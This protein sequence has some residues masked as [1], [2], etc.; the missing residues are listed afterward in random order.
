[1]L[2]HIAAR[3]NTAHITYAL[4]ASSLLYFKGLVK[5][6]HDFDFEVTLADALRARDI[7]RGMGTLRPSVRGDYKI[8]YSFEFTV[9]GGEV[10]LMDVFSFSRF[11]MLRR[12]FL[13]QSCGRACLP[14]LGSDLHHIPLF[15]PSS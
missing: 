13:C 11:D 8:K 14:G 10:G 15:L 3:F 7:L 12:L 4:G 5:E 1:M 9:D 2:A 6:F